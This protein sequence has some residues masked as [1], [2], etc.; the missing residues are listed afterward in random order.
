MDWPLTTAETITGAISA[1]S[2]AVAVFAAVSTVWFAKRKLTRD[3]VN[4][5]ITMVAARKT[6]FEDI[7]KWAD[8]LVDLL[9]EAIHLCDLDPKQVM[10]ETF[11]D[12]RHRLRIALSAMI[13]RGRWFFPNIQVDDHGAQKELGYRGYRHELLN[14]LVRAYQCLGRLDYRNGDNNTSIRDQL[15]AAKRHFVGRVQEIIDPATQ[16]SE[17]DRIQSAVQK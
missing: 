14:G 11:F 9:T 6:Y 16:R 8:E 1:F 4:Q 10:G 15:T 17:F 12:R 5:R 7:R 3:L 13:D 2:A